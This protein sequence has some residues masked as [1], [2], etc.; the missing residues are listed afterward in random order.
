MRS[1][2]HVGRAVRTR[3]EH[4]GDC[5]E[6]AGPSECI[7]QNLVRSAPST[8]SKATSMSVSNIVVLPVVASPPRR[9]IP[10][11]HRPRHVF[12]DTMSHLNR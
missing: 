4:A 3:E 8:A 11:R 9:G 2:L 5:L 6:I 7:V 1:R 12:L 10:H